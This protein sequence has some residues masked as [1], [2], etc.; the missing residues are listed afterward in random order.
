MTKKDYIKIAKIL[1]DSNTQDVQ[2]YY[3]RND[4]RHTL[5]P[6]AYIISELCKIFE[7]DNPRF[8]AETFIEAAK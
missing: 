8:K 2:H 5:L 6:K 7:K 4:G 1:K 3:R